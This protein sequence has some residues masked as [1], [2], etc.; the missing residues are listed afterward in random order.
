MKT[1]FLHGL[2]Q[3]K[4]SWQQM[5][6]YLENKIDPIYLDLAELNAGQKL[7][8]E[9]LYAGLRQKLSMITPP[10]KLCGLSLG[11]ILALN[12][13]INESDKVAE[14]ILIAPQFKIP[15]ALFSIQNIIF[16]C[17]P[18]KTFNSMGLPKKSVLSLTKSMRSLDFTNS[19]TAITTNTVIVCG[20]QDKA[21]K[22]AAHELA[23]RLPHA[24]TVVIENA[25]HELNLD[26]PRALAQLLYNLND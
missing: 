23:K 20:Q 4:T 3:D 22:K 1:V 11:A 24:K 19:L 8:Y 15:K 13:A 16:R 25:G 5:D 17:L 6:Y 18:P 21:N 9:N 12:F 14:L 26:N 10:F 7:T 2:G